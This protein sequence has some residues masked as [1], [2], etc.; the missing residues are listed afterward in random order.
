MRLFAST[1]RVSGCRAGFLSIFGILL[2]GS[3]CF[4]EYSS[5][6]STSDTCSFCHS[7]GFSALI[8]SRGNELSISGDW[9]STMMG[10]AFRD[11]LFRAK[12]ESEVKRNPKLAGAIED[13]CTTCHAPMART[14]A[15]WD[16]AQHYSLSEAEGSELAWDSVSCTVCHQ[17]QDTNLG[18]KESFSGSYSIRDD[19]KIFGPYKNVFANPMLNHVNYLPLYGQQVDKP[20]LCAT[21]HTLFTPYVDKAGNIAGE[22]PEQTPYLEWLNSDYSSPDNYQSCQDCHM[23]KIDEPIKITNRPPWYKKKQSPFWMHHFTGGNTFVLKM[24]M[25][26]RQNLGVVATDSQFKKTIKRTEERL[27]NDSAEI[28]IEHTEL[29][30]NRL[31]VVVKVINKTG[32]KF[33]TGFPSR[34]VW[35]RLHVKDGQEHVLF[36]SGNWTAQGNI[37]GLDENFERHYDTINSPEQVQIYQAVMGDV[38]GVLT[39]TLLEA[40]MYL[41][42]NRLVPKGF[43]KSG[44]MTEHTLMTGKVVDDTNFNMEDGQEGSGA[45][46]ITY[47]IPINSGRHPLAIQAQLM[48]QT[49]TPRFIENLLVDDTPAVSR[50]QKMYAQSGNDPIVVDSLT[51]A[52]A[53]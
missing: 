39:H 12:L 33:P 10:N 35:I 36:D 18:Q 43:V 28:S 11:P 7:S 17:I 50:L 26:N 23:P 25:A 52:L 24:L 53:E 8:D 41:K 44:S 15:V 1:R 4:A 38:E 22:F 3:T 16:G 46:Y 20:E 9:G 6:F 21:C 31:K 32:H 29:E 5:L 42:D 45:D 51:L 27:T 40:A 19:R 14:Q 49:S 13:K 37:V 47:D 34:R 2:F 48:Y 30:N